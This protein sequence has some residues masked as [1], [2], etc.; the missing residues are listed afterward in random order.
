[1]TQPAGEVTQ[2]AGDEN[3]VQIQMVK[4]DSI[5]SLLYSD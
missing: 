1:M 2:P 4:A 3:L 5:G